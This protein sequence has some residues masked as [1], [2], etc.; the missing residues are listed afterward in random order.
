VVLHFTN[1]SVKLVYVSDISY[2]THK[3][4]SEIQDLVLNICC[5]IL[6]DKTFDRI[7][8]LSYKVRVLVH[9]LFYCIVQS[10]TMEFWVL[11]GLFVLTHG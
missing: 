6:A 5:T 11:L 4:N 3:I 8:G 1:T 10:I 2:K 7:V 9:L